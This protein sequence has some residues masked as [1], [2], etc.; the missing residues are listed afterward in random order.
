MG[1]KSKAPKG[2]QGAA[3]YKANVE[4]RGLTTVVDDVRKKV[5]KRTKRTSG[6]VRSA[7]S[8]SRS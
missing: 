4:A 2:P 5:A 6:R 8:E 7:V 1:K 3:A